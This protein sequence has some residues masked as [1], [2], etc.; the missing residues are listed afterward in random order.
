MAKNSSRQMQEGVRRLNYFLEL[1]S[2]GLPGTVLKLVKEA[3][4][5]LDRDIRKRRDGREREA[6]K[7]TRSDQ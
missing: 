3:K 5:R 6:F 7:R 2:D 4:K 1:E